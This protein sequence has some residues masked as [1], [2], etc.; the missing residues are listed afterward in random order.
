MSSPQ[1]MKM[2]CDICGHPGVC[3]FTHLGDTELQ[4]IMGTMSSFRYEPGQILWQEGVYRPGCFVLCAGTADLAVTNSEGKR[5][6]VLSL[7]AGDIIPCLDG[8]RAGDPTRRFAVQVESTSRVLV[9]YLPSESFGYLM[10]RYPSIAARVVEK[11]SATVLQLVR[12]IGVSAYCDVQARLAGIL[13]DLQETGQLEHLPSQQ[14]LAE[15]AGASR[16]AVN[17]TLRH[18]N[19][20]KIIIMEGHKIK[21]VDKRRLQE[22]QV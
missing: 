14:V 1:A 9:H 19:H 5:R 8:V 13:L 3:P 12:Q 21:I 15:L 10:I 2:Q 7:Q 22:L 18:L 6:I 20:E 16:E 4:E 11:L 17:K